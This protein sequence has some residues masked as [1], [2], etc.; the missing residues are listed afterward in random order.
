MLYLFIWFI[1][2]NYSYFYD[3]LWEFW[4]FCESFFYF[5]LVGFG[6]FLF[7]L[8]VKW[9]YFFVL[10]NDKGCYKWYS[11]LKVDFIFI[12]VLYFRRE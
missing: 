6:D 4:S 8:L 7:V 12:C 9:E 11:I 1:W 3:S 5:I 10:G 2:D